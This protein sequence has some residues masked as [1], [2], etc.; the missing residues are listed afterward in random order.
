MREWGSRYGVRTFFFQHGGFSAKVLESPLGYSI[1]P[2]RISAEL[3][4]T[5]A[6]RVLVSEY[7]L[8]GASG[9]LSSWKVG[10]AVIVGRVFSCL[11]SAL[12]YLEG[13]FQV[14]P[15]IFSWC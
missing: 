9:E 14:S 12:C 10:K 15:H 11:A 1:F 8:S 4:C 13:F 5:L 7:L 3:G 6:F 2:P